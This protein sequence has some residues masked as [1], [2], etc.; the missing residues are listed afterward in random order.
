MSLYVLMPLN[1]IVCNCEWCPYSTVSH[2]IFILLSSIPEPSSCGLKVSICLI[3]RYL[4][5][6]CFFGHS[7]DRIDDFSI[8]FDYYQ[9]Y[10]WVFYNCVC[11]L[12]SGSLAFRG[13]T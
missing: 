13:N 9:M 4:I 3:G 6:R 2:H 8:Y 12:S 7:L 11:V 1:V 5:R 10:L